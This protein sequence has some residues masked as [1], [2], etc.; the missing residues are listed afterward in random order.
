MIS[1]MLFIEDRVVLNDRQVEVLDHITDREAATFPFYLG[2]STDP[3]KVFN[4]FLMRRNREFIGQ[5]GPVVSRFYD[6]FYNIFISFCESHDIKVKNVLRAAV[7]YSIYYKD[8]VAFAHTDHEFD[9]CN[10]IMYLTDC[11]GGSTNIHDDAGKIIKSISVEKHKA[12][13]FPGESHSIS[14][15]EPGQDRMVLVFTFIKE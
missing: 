8:F 9:H 14:E 11:V 13:I 5:P 6:F 3:N 10:F 7:N 4:H 2:W 12:I 1:D 15:F